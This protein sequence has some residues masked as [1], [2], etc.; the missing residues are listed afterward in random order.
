MST[1]ADRAKAFFSQRRPERTDRT[2]KTHVLSVLSVPTAGVPKKREE[3]SSVSSVGVVALFENRALADELMAAAT[4]ACHHHGD[5]TQEREEMRQEVLNTPE[6]LRADLLAHLSETYPQISTTPEVG[7]DKTAETPDDRRRCTDC[8][9]YLPGRC[10]NHKAAG[11][12]ASAIGRDLAILP[13]RCPGFK[14]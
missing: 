2:A 10:G 7:T 11:L 5:G 12:S 3:V 6:H 9:H 8:A 14:P 4:R 13:Q 1:W